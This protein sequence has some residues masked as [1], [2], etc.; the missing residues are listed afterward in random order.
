MIQ[1]HAASGCEG[2]QVL[3]AVGT[4][5]TVAV[6]S[7]RAIHK[8]EQ[9]ARAVD[10]TA[11]KAAAH[12]MGTTQEQQQAAHTG[13]TQGGVGV[14]SRLA[15]ALGRSGNGSGNGSATSGSTAGDGDK[16]STAGDAK[17]TPSGAPSTAAEREALLQ[18]L[19]ETMEA[20]AA[21]D[22][23]SVS[24]AAAAA[25]TATTPPSS[26]P[27]SSTPGKSAPTSLRMIHPIAHAA[28]ETEL[29]HHLEQA[30]LLP[31]YLGVTSGLSST[32][33]MAQELVGESLGCVG[34][35]GDAARLQ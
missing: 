24:P 1:E 13:E 25:A 33:D 20:L 28:R 4:G 17:R 7:Q 31:D 14:L 15:S 35:G 32:R 21:A 18:E 2:S 16:S 22:S 10:A 9:H 23:A 11:S 12:A 8:L 27:S 29:R 6:V 30:G 34:G 19:V 3:T 26:S 5:A